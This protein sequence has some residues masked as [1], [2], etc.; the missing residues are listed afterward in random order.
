MSSRDHLLGELMKEAQAGNE[1]SYQT[2]LTEVYMFL[3]SY[4]NS[5]IFNKSQ[6]DDVIQET[7]MAV[8]NSR[9]TYDNSKSFMSWLLAITH[10]KVSDQLR[11]QFKQ[12]TQ[13]L[14]DTH[15]DSN[16][17]TLNKLI[18]HENFQLLNQALSELEEKPKQIVTLLK[19]EGLK[20]S[21]VADR[22]KLTESN[23]KVIA[24]RAYQSLELKLR[25]KL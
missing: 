11:V 9:A 16:A 17:D 7:L 5:K 21:E 18:E 3:E 1:S 24:H 14:E 12:K 20:I 8:H 19:L 4:L 15:I 10:Y 25:S 2:L 6:I 13:E 22:L 23:V